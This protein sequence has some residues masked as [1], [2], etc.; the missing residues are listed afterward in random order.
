V[1]L[2]YDERGTGPAVV[3]L[4]AGIADRREW[5]D[6]LEPIAAAGYRVIAPD[7]PGFG[8]APASPDYTHWI[9]VA[10]TMEAAGASPAV[11]VGNSFGAAVALRVAVVDPARVRALALVSCLPEELEPSTELGKAWEREEQALDRGDVEAAVEAIVGAFLLPDAPPDLREL[12]ASAQRRAFEIQLAAG[13]VEPAAD[14]V[15]DDPSLLGGIAVPTLIATGEHDMPDYHDG[16][17]WF[18]RMIPGSRSVVIEGARHLA[19][20]ERP[21]AF[22]EL[23]LGWLGELGD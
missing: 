23:M 19:P 11:L 1:L 4:H 16:A 22:R 8:A 18:E 21:E 6:H 13:P 5:S 10:E 15:E 2:P 7:L 20:L 9:D 12:V 14:P 3:L 17:D